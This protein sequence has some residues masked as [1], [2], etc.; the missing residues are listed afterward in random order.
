MTNCRT[1]PVLHPGPAPPPN[2]VAPAPGI[3]RDFLQKLPQYAGGGGGATSP[4]GLVR[5]GGKAQRG[6]IRMGLSILLNY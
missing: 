4:D 1:F 6:F 2:G 3:Y 5:R